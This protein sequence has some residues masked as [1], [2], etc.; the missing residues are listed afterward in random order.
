MIQES[1]LTLYK[2]KLKQKYNL[3]VLVVEKINKVIINSQKQFSKKAS[4][5]V[6]I[7]IKIETKTIIIIII[8]KIIG[9]CH[10]I[11]ISELACYLK[12]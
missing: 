8:I 9:R 1:K 10:K 3:T 5:K 4:A 11:N 2:V 6:E 7:K 12:V